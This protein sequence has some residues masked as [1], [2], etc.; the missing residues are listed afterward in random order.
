MTLKTNL[1]VA[2]MGTLLGV[3]PIS[4]LAQVQ[5]ANCNLPA[6]NF[7]LELRVGLTCGVAATATVQSFF[8]KIKPNTPDGLRS[9]VPGYNDASVAQV[10]ARFNGVKLNLSLPDP[11]GTVIFNIPELDYSRT[12]TAAT[13]DQSIDLLIDDL[14]KGDILARIM[15]YQARNTPTSPITGVGGL[16]PMVIATDFNQNFTDFA[17]NI[18]G[19]LQDAQVGGTGNLAGAALLLGSFTTDSKDGMRNKIKVATL[20]LSYTFR[21]GIDPRQQLALSIPLSTV[22]VNGARSYSGG[23]GMAYRFPINDSW[24]LVPA[25]RLSAVG[26]VDLATVSAVYSMGL[27]SVYLWDMG[28]YSIA[29]GNMLSYNATTKFRSGDYAFDPK[30]SNTSLR[31]GVLVSQPVV[32]E[33]KKMSVEYSLVD[34]RFVG[35]T[36]P[37]VNQYQEFGITV[38]TNKNAYSA[39]TFV[40]A[41]LTLTHGKGT[42]GAMA[43]IGY[44]F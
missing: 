14:K 12:F 3:C 15:A 39:R 28:R 1:W 42:K 43:N 34:T 13:R 33:G 31:N 20:P 18:T 9:I 44:W 29:M 8:D 19:P 35:G 17:T 36:K 30:I 5:P 26:S 37:Y 24:T 22:D 38:G 10:A 11:N 16:M 21:N 2:S 41:G 32:W 27:T 4:G 6:G 25:G 23:I 40:R 7:A